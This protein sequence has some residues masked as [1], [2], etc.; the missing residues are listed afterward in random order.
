MRSTASSGRACRASPAACGRCPTGASS[1]AS[2]RT[3]LLDRLAYLRVHADV[4]MDRA[5]TRGDPA[6]DDGDG[7]PDAAERARLPRAGRRQRIVHRPARRDPQAV[8]GAAGGRPQAPPGDG[9]P[10]RGAGGGPRAARPRGR[11]SGSSSAT[12]CRAPTSPR[13]PGVDTLHI[14]GA[15]R[16]Y[17]AIVYG[18]GPEG[19]ERRRRDDPVLHKPFSAELGNLTPIIVVPGRWSSAGAGLP[20]REHRDDADQQ[21]GVQ[22][23]DVAGDRHGRRLAPARGAAGPDPAAPRAAPHAPRLLPGRRGPVRGLRRGPSRGRAVR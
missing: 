6:G 2:C 4:W 18:T 23:H 3:D 20:R 9:A 11:A 12:T 19:A 5:V 14:T 10:R 8:R 22:L 17:D 21:R 15:D 16:T 1:P 7:L 13:H